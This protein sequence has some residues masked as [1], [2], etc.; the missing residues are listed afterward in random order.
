MSAVVVVVSAAVEVVVAAVEVVAAVVVV[1]AELSTLAA[2]KIWLI[3]AETLEFDAKIA[4]ELLR[5]PALMLLELAGDELELLFEL[6]GVL[7][8]ETTTPPP[9]KNGLTKLQKMPS[10][11]FDCNLTDRN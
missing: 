2:A 6:L 1:S 4:L 11:P 5:A 8:E 7:P 9:G 3:F 10:T